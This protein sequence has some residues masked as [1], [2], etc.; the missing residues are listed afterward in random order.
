MSQYKSILEELFNGN[1]IIG[2]S[3][4]PKGETAEF[5]RKAL[6]E[7]SQKLKDNLSNEQYKLH[8]EYMD[9]AYD[10]YNDEVYKAYLQG[11]YF[12]LRL[13]AESFHNSEL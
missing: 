9:S 2:E 3:L 7:M 5:H 10:T 8:E 12:G 1:I 6:S 4:Q 11:V 13:M